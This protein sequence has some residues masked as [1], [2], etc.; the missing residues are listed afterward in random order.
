MVRMPKF[1]ANISFMFVESP[2][3]E[4]YQLA[5]NAGFKAVESGF[6]Y[7]L[8]PDEVVAA[9]NAAGIDQVLLNV[10]TGNFNIGSFIEDMHLFSIQVMLQRENWD[11]QHFRARENSLRIV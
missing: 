2:F 9:K 1:C 10:Y 6:P 8:N 3:L 4:R 7:G 11:L 5:K